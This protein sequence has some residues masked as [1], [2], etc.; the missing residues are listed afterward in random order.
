MD[1]LP[2]LT[3]KSI[4]L[5]L[6]LS[7]CTLYELPS[8]DTTISPSSKGKKSKQPKELKVIAG[9]VTDN[10]FDRGLVDDEPLANDIL[11]EH[12]A[13]YRDTAIRNFNGTVL[14]YVTPVS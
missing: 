3:M 12:S 5:F 7:I 9:P 10:V 6:L 2:F 11:M 4:H 13:Y 14:G 1:V 8:I